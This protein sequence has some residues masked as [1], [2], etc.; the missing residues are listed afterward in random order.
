MA[1]RGIEL[2]R[3]QINAAGGIRGAK[4]EIRFQDDS[5]SGPTAARIAQQ[6]VDAPEVLAVVGHM[7]S[8]AMLA[9]ARV[10]DGNLTAVATT[11][12][13][14]AL[15][16]IS[17]WVFRV[18]SSDSVNG[19]QLAKAANDMGLRRAGILYENDGYG[20]G[21]SASFHGAF[22]GQVISD[23]PISG[24]IANAEPYIAF[25]KREHPDVVLV[26]GNDASAL[27]ILREA[28][29]Q[30][31][32]TQFIGGDGWTPVVQDPAASE[33]ALI[34]APF[35]SD[36]PRPSA[37]QFVAAFAAAYHMEPDFNSALGYDATLT[38]ARAVG[39][40]GPDRDAIRKWLRDL[41]EKT[42]VPGASGPIRFQR[43]G[44]PVGRGIVLTRVHRGRLVP[45]STR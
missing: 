37:R 35:T 18:I 5:A 9:A 1:R 33:G 36:D 24:D 23:D 7:S 29:R 44:D 31:L 22:K 45:E 42:A 27:V 12:T 38:L 17:P 43:N 19:V 32:T 30:Q 8:G 16:G 26:A 13:T 40:V 6:F 28:R 10:Y 41:N 25:L 4:L 14:P 11:V 3:D 20:R 2:A 15:S 39:A 21:L 34:G